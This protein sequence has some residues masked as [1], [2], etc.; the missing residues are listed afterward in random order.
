MRMTTADELVRVMGKFRGNVDYSDAP[1]GFFGFVRDTF[2]QLAKEDEYAA[3]YDDCDAPVYPT[4]GHKDDSYDDVVRNFYATWTRFA[5][6]KTFAWLDRYRLSDAPDRR[7]RRLMEK[8]NQKFRDDGRREFNGAVQ[9]LVAFVR[10]RDPRYTPLAQSD[11]DKAKAQRDARAAQAVRARAAQLAKLEQE[12]QTVPAWA[13][14]RTVEELQEESEDEIEEELYECVACNKT[15]KSERQYEA[16]EKSKKH[17]KAIQS[18]RKR[19]ENDNAKLNLGDGVVSS[20]VITP[21]EDEPG[22]DTTEELLQ[23]LVEITVELKVDDQSGDGKADGTPLQG[24]LSAYTQVD[25]ET[26]DPGGIDSVEN[27]GEDDEEFDSRPTS[28]PRVGCFATTQAPSA[29]PNTYPSRSTESSPSRPATP[30]VGKAALKRAKKAAKQADLEQL[31]AK[32]KC[33]GCD[34]NFP[35]KNQLFDHLQDHPKH[36]ALKAASGKK[37]KKR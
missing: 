15:F 9:T 12:T 6:A 24:V 26:L 21:A 4:F 17:Q 34:A 29:P 23:D 3:A 37:G 14:A 5:T 20:G 19:M 30:K 10:K 11:E 18:L 33:Q 2:E 13:S 7:T 27:N 22:A 28:K 25:G 31:E 8:E 35:S 32:H 16:H 36:A 1:N